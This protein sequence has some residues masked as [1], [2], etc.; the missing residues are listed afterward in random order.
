MILL[1]LAYSVLLL[2]SAICLPTELLFF[3]IRWIFTG[4]SFGETLFIK[5]LEQM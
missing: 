5:C 2:L 1:R 3:I 4:K